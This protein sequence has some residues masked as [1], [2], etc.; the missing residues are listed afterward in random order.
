[1][2]I[3]LDTDSIIPGGKYH[4]RRDYMDFPDLD[5]KLVYTPFYPVNISDF[6]HSDNT[7]ERLKERDFLILRKGMRL[8]SFKTQCIH[9]RH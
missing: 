4:N 6:S 2:G 5:D 7:F 8:C 3:N 1:M 9:K